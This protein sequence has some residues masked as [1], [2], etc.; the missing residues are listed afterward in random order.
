[1]AL[2]NGTEK[3]PAEDLT[4][5]NSLKLILLSLSLSPSVI[6]FWIISRTL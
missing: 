6:S 3:N 2:E 1:M 5:T 4:E